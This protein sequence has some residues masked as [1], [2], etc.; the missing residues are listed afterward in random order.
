MNEERR[1]PRVSL[2]TEVWLGQDGIFTRAQGT[3]PDLS[4][5]GAFVETADGFPIGSVLSLRFMLPG[6]RDLISC[7]VSVR[8]VRN[9]GAG[10]GVQFLDMSQDDRHLVGAFVSDGGPGSS[11]VLAPAE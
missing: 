2:H 6:V 1:H 10:L 7:A 9:D 4:E 5:G 11:G 8:N 3:F